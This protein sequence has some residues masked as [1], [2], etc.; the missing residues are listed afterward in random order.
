MQVKLPAHSAGLA[1]HLPVKKYALQ[2]LRKVRLSLIKE[3]LPPHDSFFKQ[4]L[5]LNHVTFIISYK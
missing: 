2:S 1:G 5:F 4:V 3:P